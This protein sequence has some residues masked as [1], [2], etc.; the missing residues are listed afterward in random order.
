MS[1]SPRDESPPDGASPAGEGPREKLRG[2][3]RTIAKAGWATRPQ[4][5]ALVRNGRVRVD[6]R[7]TRDPHLGVALSS[8]I[9]IDGLR[10]VE[11]PRRYFAWHKPAHVSVGPGER[12]RRRASPEGLPPG[13]V[14]LRAAGRLDPETTG[15]VLIS[16]D[17]AWNANATGGAGLEKEY[18]VRIAGAFSELEF[19]V[20]TAG[21]HIPKLGFVRP[22]T[23]RVEERGE[24]WTIL[25]L[26]ML[27]GKNR[28]I[29]RIFSTLRHEVLALQR[30]RIGPVRLDGLAPNLVRP[31][32]ESEVELVRRGRPRVPRRRPGTTDG[33]GERRGGAR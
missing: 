18:L 26:V 9:R 15:L 5:E 6:G 29:R 10:L 32:T 14:G 31:L 24:G 22:V 12:D 7:V 30:I 11:A 27:E 13:I 20:V 3:A 4:A 16:N 1:P 19:G 17:P 23:A 21:M 2:L 25:R 8:D 28:Q 33:A